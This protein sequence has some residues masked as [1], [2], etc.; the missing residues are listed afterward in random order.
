MHLLDH[1]IRFSVE[2]RL[3]VL[4]AALA[5]SIYGAVTAARMPVDV[6]PDLTA[7]TV[8]VVTEAHGLAPEEVE[9]LVTF[10]V[11][12]AMNGATGVRRVRSASGIGISIVWVEFDW[13]TDIHVARQIVTEKLQGVASQIPPDIE[14]PTLAPISSIMGEIL[15]IGLRSEKHQPMEVREAAEWLVRRRLLGVTG[16]AQVVP[17]GAARRQYQV[18][19]DP[20]R[21]LRHQVKVDEVVAALAES[22]QNA[23]GGFVARGAQERLIRAVGRLRS[24]A[25]LEASVVALRGDTP[26]AVRQ[27]ADVVVG[28]GIARG[29]GSVDARAAVVMGILKQPGSNTLELTTRIEAT[30]TEIQKSL[31]D[32]MVLERELMRQADFIETGVG[33]VA[34]ALRDGA[35]LVA[36][37]LF[38]FLWNARAA[39]ISLAALPISLLVAVLAMKAMDVGINTMSL[40]GLTIAIGALVDDAIIDVENVFRRLRENLALP[41]EERRS[42]LQVVVEA[43]AE[44]RGSI[45]FATLIVMLVFLPVFFLTGVEGRLLAPLGFA[46]LVAIFASL[47]V[48]L[49]VTPALCAYLL[50]GRFRLPAGEP[51]LVRLLKRGY[52]PLL[53]GAV[54]RPAIVGGAAIALVAGALVLVPFL[55]RTFLPEFHEGALTI[56]AVTLPGTSLVES[57]K[58]GRR[59]E[60]LLQEVP[61]V[62]STARRTG[63]AELDEHAQDV[64]ASEIDVRLRSGRSRDAVLADIRRRLSAVPGVVLTIGQ[65]ISHRI[66]H[67]LSGTRASIAVKIFGDD[68]A[69]LRRVAEEVRGVMAGVEGAVDVSIEQQ[70]DIPQLAIVFDRDRIARYGLRAGALAESVETALAGHVVTQVLEEQRTYDVVVRYADRHRADRDAVA[71]ALID[72]PLGPKVP[73]SMLAEIRDDT[74]PNTITREKVGRKMV[75]QANTSGRDLGGVIDDIRAAIG[76]RIELPTG[77]YVEYGGQFESQEQASRTIYLLG[78]VVIAGIFLLLYL[79][80]RSGKTALVVMVNL[81]LALVGGVAAA[82]LAGGVLSV[83]SLVGFITLFGIATRNGIMML[84]HYEHL[85][86]VEG[87]SFDE[88][89]ERGSLERLSPVLMTALCAGLALLPLVLAGSEPGNEIQAPMGVVILGGLLTSTALNM[90]LVPALY[91]R[92]FRPPRD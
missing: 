85:R 13:D 83:G 87:A 37:I 36:I 8:T 45:V 11:E 58:L 66:D 67:M 4:V 57:D 51:A 35:I 60:T 80:F 61:E 55:G 75:V 78:A 84:S 42:P 20:E 26:V 73:L 52:L 31:P 18:L 86:T 53:R 82:T 72:T 71:A 74:G 70:V 79:A 46:Y 89:V 38:L 63:R 12:S 41:D 9:S 17:T 43:S 62:V 27:I 50:A 68:L 33:N 88:A 24:K 2:R 30:L 34:T 40:G 10:P 19:L 77:Y 32:G 1:I 3:F 5:V 6:F 39:L 7:P 69:E 21:M 92:L 54:A 48:A 65:P 49:T 76:E 44:I 14:P 56:G 90:L 59:L 16:V 64:N 29:E 91:A 25:D 81:P 47:V 23:T 28:P 22:N 15:F